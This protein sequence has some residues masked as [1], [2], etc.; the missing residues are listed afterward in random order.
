VKAPYVTLAQNANAGDAVLHLASPAAGWLVGDKLQLPDTRQLN[1]GNEGT[2]YTSQAESMTIQSISAGGLTITLTAPLQYSHLGGYDAS[3]SLRYL[4]QVVNMTRNISIHSQS[5][6]GTRGYALFT[7]RANVNINF[8]SFGGMGRTTDKAIDNTTF[9]ASGNVTHLGANEANRNAITFLNLFGPTTPQANGYQFTFNG[10]VVTCPLTPMP[11]IWGINVVNSY[12]GLIQNNDVVNWAGAGVMVDNVSSYNNF[13]GNMVMR[14]NGTGQRGS[15]DMGLA[16]DGYWFGNPNNSV[17]NNIVTDLVVTG[18][19]G[20]GFE[21]YASNALGT[22]LGLL[23]IPAYQGADPSQPG[24]SQSVDMNLMP[25]RAFANNEVYGVAPIG[26][27]YWDINYDPTSPLPISSSGGTVQNFVTWN[28]WSTGIY[29]YQASNITVNG[30][31]CLGDAAQLAGGSGGIGMQFQDYYVANMVIEN[32]DIEDQGIGILAPDTTNGTITIENSYLADQNGIF[33]QGLWSVAYTPIYIPS[34][35]L[36]IDNVNFTAPLAGQSFTAINM[37]WQLNAVDPV[38]TLDQVLVYNYDGVAG[39]N[40]QVFYTQQ[41]ANF[42]VP[43][44]VLNSDGTPKV[45][46]AP[47]AGLTNAQAWAQYHVAVAGM[48]APG[49]ATTMNNIVGLVAPI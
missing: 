45:M 47:V 35:H 1:S 31:V 21:I 33:V 44:T 8:T 19:Y 3:G 37:A 43:Q 49:N 20:Y 2:N 17:T 30:F 36:V 40:F 4:P 23:N 15:G 39:N 34:R 16:G 32:A 14:I 5:A 7:A 26:L 25:L 9:N 41:A 48:V 6:T 12:Y 11:F 22:F 28:L 42:I 24:Q 10:N 46:G 13:T 38:T 29:G 18:P 27:S